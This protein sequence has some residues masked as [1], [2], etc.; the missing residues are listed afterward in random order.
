MFPHSYKHHLYV[1]DSSPQLVSGSSGI[2]VPFSFSRV[3]QF[4]LKYTA[5]LLRCQLPPNV[6]FHSQA[7]SRASHIGN[8]AIH[9]APPFMYHSSTVTSEFTFSTLN[10]GPCT[11]LLKLETQCHL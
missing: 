6:Y 3:T 9:S 4:G 5:T 1:S 11:Q 7:I 8:P 10:W 2:V